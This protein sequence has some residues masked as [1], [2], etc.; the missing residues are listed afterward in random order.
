MRR[1][2]M[3]K[4]FVKR[5]GDSGM[6]ILHLTDET[7]DEAVKEGSA[8]VDF[9]ATWCGPCK[10]LSPILEDIAEEVPSEIKII[11][12]DIDKNEE[13]VKKYRIMS[14][15]TLVFLK[16]GEV[17]EKVTGFQSKQELLELIK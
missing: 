4:L 16:D 2:I 15:P 17:V 14:V 3:R 11:K 6:T 5:K 10:R 13:L 7:F 1:K 8:L 9:Y 12:V